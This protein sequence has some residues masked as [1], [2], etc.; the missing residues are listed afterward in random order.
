MTSSTEPSTVVE[1]LRVIPPRLAGVLK[2][3]PQ[4]EFDVVPA[5]DMW[6]LAEILAHIRASNDIVAYRAYMILAR[7]NPPL[8]A[9][10]ERRWAVIAGYARRDVLDSLETYARQRE[11]LVQMLARLAAEDWQ[12]TGMHEQRGKVTLLDVLTTLVEHEEEHLAQI[13]MTIA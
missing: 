6:S 3:R 1:R 4:A 5:P 7:D 11:E 2:G 8:P 10:D 9:L 12:R 13:E